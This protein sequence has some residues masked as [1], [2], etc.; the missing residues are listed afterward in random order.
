M[1]LPVPPALGKTA[2]PIRQAVRRMRW[3]KQSFA[4]QVDLISEASGV[5]YQIHSD[6]L[7]RAFI[8]W[9]RV[10]EAQKPT[11]PKARQAYVGFAS[12]VMLRQLI[13]LAPL[14]VVSVPAGSD[15]SNPAYYWPEGY[16]YVAYCLNVRA[17][18]LAQ[19]FDAELELTPDLG[20][21][22]T[23]WSFKENVTEDPARAIAFL[24]LFSGGNPDWAQPSL[25][26][27]KPKALAG[28]NYQ[29]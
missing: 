1:D 10:F 8:E 3:F 28:R 13:N 4:Q 5:E 23:W 11:Q 27:D 6:R 9:L 20:D 24:D 25:F 2:G 14:E 15:R 7:A 29:E 21:I 16:V 22:R 17:G 12:G 18:V 19:D 26:Y